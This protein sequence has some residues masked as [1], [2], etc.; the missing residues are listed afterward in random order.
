MSRSYTENPRS[1]DVYGE[2]GGGSENSN[3]FVV[4]GGREHVVI[5][6]LK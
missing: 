6:M 5:E 3:K 2:R 1:A 4:V